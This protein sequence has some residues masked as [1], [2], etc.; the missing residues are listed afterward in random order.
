[1]KYALLLFVLTV[2]SFV[3][4]QSKPDR[5][6][7]YVNKK[8]EVVIDTDYKWA[9]D[10]ENGRAQFK[11]V[12]RTGNKAYY[13]YGFIDTK[14]REVIP[15]I[16]EKVYQFAEGVDVTWV[17][18]RGD[19]KFIL[20]DKNGQRVGNNAFE[21][22]G[23]WIEGMCQVGVPGP[24][25]DYNGNP[26]Y[27]HGFVNLR[28]EI[29]ID[30]SEGYMGA[31]AYSDGLVCLAKEGTGYGFL[32]KTGKVV[33]PL[34][35]KQ[36]GYSGFIDGLCRVK[37]NGKT[38]LIDKTGK[39]VVEPKYSTVTSFSEGLMIV[40]LGK[41][42][43]Y[44]DFGYCDFNN[45]VVIKG[46]FDSASPFDGGFARV[47][48]GDKDGLI[49]KEGNIVIPFE[50]ESVYNNI[51]ERGY[52]RTYNDGEF[53]YFDRTGKPISEMEAKMSSDLEPEPF[54]IFNRSEK[55]GY[56]YN[57]QGKKVCDQPFCRMGEFGPEGLALVQLCE[58]VSYSSGSI[59]TP[60][61]DSKEVSSALKKP[62]ADWSKHHNSQFHT[63]FS[64][65]T[66]V[67]EEVVKQKN[68]LPQL[69][70]NARTNS[71][72]V[73][74]VVSELAKKISSKSVPRTLEKTKDKV[75]E[76]L[77]ASST[78]TLTTSINGTQCLQSQLRKDK[79]VYNYYIA[80]KEK[81]MY[82]WILVTVGENKEL[83]EAFFESIELTD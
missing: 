40:A 48:K 41:S 78:N 27:R 12:V 21:K 77:G 60:A 23:Y 36:A 64:A 37:K 15:A 72:Q 76:S 45:E 26:L 13:N 81:T 67:V 2:H 73:T 9:D 35:Y 71:V 5:H 66:K 54:A 38:G 30:P 39:W 55:Q 59:S 83:S 19:S 63:S 6:F 52:F 42:G 62:L 14:G 17:K 34:Q 16:Y 11:K 28:C 20:I 24:E 1:M 7:A 75:A 70:A 58:G 68:G 31:P 29:I 8:G 56:Y 22:V 80:I 4:A 79:L 44:K 25:K 50:H 47:R 69:K 18:K 51:T 3:F 57:K 33:I 43:G 61:E 82:Q 46:P 74:V 65:P 49:D 10:F 53:S 32:D